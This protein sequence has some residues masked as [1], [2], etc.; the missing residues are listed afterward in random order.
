MISLND[1]GMRFGGQRLFEG[2]RWQL[3]AGGPGCRGR[4][5]HIQYLRQAVRCQRTTVSGCTI[6]SGERQPGQYLE[7]HDQKRRS[8]GFVR[9]RAR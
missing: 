6:T 4:L 5:F 9:V 3:S 2:V 1:L 7:S 8:A